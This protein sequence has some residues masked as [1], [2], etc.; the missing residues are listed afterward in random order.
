MALPQCSVC[1]S[2]VGLQRALRGW[3]RRE[4]LTYP[5]TMRDGHREEFPMRWLCETCER[6][7]EKHRKAMREDASSGG[8]RA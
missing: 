1:G 3:V 7:A 4:E 8:K 2:P 6:R 5:T